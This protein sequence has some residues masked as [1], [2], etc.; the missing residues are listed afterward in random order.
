MTN[1]QEKLIV[2]FL[3]CA[4]INVDSIHALDGIVIH[5]DELLS[6]ERYAKVKEMIPELKTLYSSSYMTSLQKPA[7]KMHKYPFINIVRQVLKSCGYQLRPKRLANGYT[8]AGKKI[9]RRIFIITL[10]LV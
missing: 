8:K 10:L 7:D 5:R 3:N 4:G 9:Y 1:L 2:S 6:E